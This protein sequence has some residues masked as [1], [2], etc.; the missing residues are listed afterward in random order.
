MMP[1][2]G[3]L[4]FAD[5]SDGYDESEFVVLGI[6]FDR[7]T[8]FRSGARFAPTTIR[9]ASSNF[10]KTMFEHDFTF[11][12]VK[13]HDAG[14]LYEE[15]TVDDMVA[16]IEEEARKMISSD[17]F[18]ISVGGEHSVSPPIVRAHGREMSVITI[19]AHL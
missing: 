6:P 12:D 13:F 18:L 11:D 4:R 1:I 16:S 17:K 19:D 14:D 9:E 7:T 2:R 3:M 10:E 5:A 15:G 8:T